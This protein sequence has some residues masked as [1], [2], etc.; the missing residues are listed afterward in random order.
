[1][2]QTLIYRILR[3]IGFP[4]T[5]TVDIVTVGIYNLG[6]ICDNLG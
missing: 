4:L 5:T 2:Q 3:N 1:M 6:V